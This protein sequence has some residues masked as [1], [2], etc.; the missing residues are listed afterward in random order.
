[1]EVHVSSR[2]S[3]GHAFILAYGVVPLLQVQRSMLSYG[4]CKSDSAAMLNNDNDPP[5]HSHEATQEMPTV[6][7][8]WQRVN[9]VWEGSGLGLEFLS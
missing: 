1:V 6:Q 5:V 2:P 3:V 4:I 7:I 9:N 8:E